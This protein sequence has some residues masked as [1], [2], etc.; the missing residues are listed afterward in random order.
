MRKTLNLVVLLSGQGSIFEALCQAIKTKQLDAKILAVISDNPQAYG[1][2]RAQENQIPTII[3]SM[4]NYTDK[5]AFQIALKETLLELSPDLIV[6]AGFMCILA[7]SIVQAFPYQILNIHPALLPKYPGLN[8]H[9]RVLASGDTEHGSTVH[10]VDEGLD[11][12]PIL[13][14]E[15]LAILSG[16]SVAELEERVKTL[17]KKLY[18][19]VLQWFAEDRIQIKQGQVFLDN[20]LLKDLN[21]F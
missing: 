8:T 4:K 15:K 6:L 21:K 10:F 16:G 5:E 14:Q 7:P 13:A 2:I 3:L 20:Q 12:G 1:L 9:A 18:P 19:K 17:E 11:S